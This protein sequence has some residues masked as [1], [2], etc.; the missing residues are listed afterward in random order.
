MN[1][2]SKVQSR[3]EVSKKYFAT[4]ANTW[5]VELYC[6]GHLL[7]T[8]DNLTFEECKQRYMLEEQN[9]NQ[10]VVIYCNTQRL[11][12]NEKWKLFW[13]RPKFNT[14]IY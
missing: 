8:Y 13:E 7:E 2:I 11:T 4:S 9:S 12:I 1:R 10:A 14:S 5:K 6:Y 3:G